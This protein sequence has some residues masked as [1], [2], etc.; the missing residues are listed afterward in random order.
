MN[1]TIAALATAPGRGGVAIVRISG[2]DALAFGRAVFRG[3]GGFSEFK[4]RYM[5]FGAVMD[6]EG[7]PV[8][9][10][11]AVF[12]PGPGSFTGEDVLEL[13]GHGGA[14]APAA[15]VLDAVG[16]LSLSLTSATSPTSFAAILSLTNEC[17]PI[18]NVT[19]TWRMPLRWRE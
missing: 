1:D 12:F 14:A 5:H 13:H 7:A 18:L 4:P 8:D 11:L 17:T 6:S 3:A 15:V 19:A 10:V 2:P 16:L 9:E